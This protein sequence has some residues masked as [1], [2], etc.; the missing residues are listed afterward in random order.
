M[1]VAGVKGRWLARIAA[2]AIGVGIVTAAGEPPAF[3]DTIVCDRRVCVGIDRSGTNVMQVTT[4]TTQG[5]DF[6]GHFYISSS[7]DSFMS[8]TVTDEMSFSNKISTPVG[9]KF[10]TGTLLCV[11]GH[12][13]VK[14]GTIIRGR[15]CLR[16]S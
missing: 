9:M 7:D 15:P 1:Y 16:I 6:F 4:Y 14:G 10:N 8:T 13:Q 11:E 5:G 3:A 2:S 12:E